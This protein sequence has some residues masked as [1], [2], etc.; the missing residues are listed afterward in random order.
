MF[1]DTTEREKIRNKEAIRL[2]LDAHMIHP[3]KQR[4][5]WIIGVCSREHRPGGWIYEGCHVTSACIEFDGDGNELDKT[6]SF[7]IDGNL[8]PPLK[9]SK[10]EW[11]WPFR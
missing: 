1:L 6:Y 9:L 3:T 2:A 10:I 7:T 8:M 5:P 4:V 11:V